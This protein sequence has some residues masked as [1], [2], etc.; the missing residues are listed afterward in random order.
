MSVR[1]LTLLCLGSLLG[2]VVGGCAEAP[3]A[4]SI[5]MSAAKSVTAA[6]SDG[7]ASDRGADASQGRGARGSASERD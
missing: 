3:Q 7:K 4:G 5:D 2:A 1:A 6:K